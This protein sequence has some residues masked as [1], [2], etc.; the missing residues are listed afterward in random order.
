MHCDEYIIIGHHALADIAR[1]Q[2]NI[3]TDIALS[4]FHLK[5][6][7]MYCSVDGSFYN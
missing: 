2:R 7:G 1:L 4:M 3:S 5:Q 6:K